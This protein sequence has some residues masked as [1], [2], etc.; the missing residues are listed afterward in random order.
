MLSAKH[1]AFSRPSSAIDLSG[2]F[3]TGVGTAS[4]L[5]ALASL[6]IQLSFLTSFMRAFTLR[7]MARARPYSRSPAIGFRWNCSRAVLDHCPDVAIHTVFRLPILPRGRKP[8]RSSPPGGWT[9]C[10]LCLPIN[11]AVPALRETPAL[12][13]SVLSHQLNLLLDPIPG[14]IWGVNSASPSAVLLWTFNASRLRV[15]VQRRMSV[16]LAAVTL[17][18]HSSHTGLG[19]NARQP[20]NFDKFLKMSL[21]LSVF[22][23]MAKSGDRSDD[24]YSFTERGRTARECRRR[25]MMFMDDPEGSHLGIGVT[26]NRHG[27]VFRPAGS[28]LRRPGRWSG[29][30]LKSMT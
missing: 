16:E 19:I 23:N 1:S 30:E 11:A 22:S 15:T 3:K 12:S 25:V 27:T 24:F 6:P 20:A 28:G 21:A 7:W 8:R 26:G 29:G 2:R 5:S 4:V 10:C 13:S 9:L 14:L 17:S 18:R